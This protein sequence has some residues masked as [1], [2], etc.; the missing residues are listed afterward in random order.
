MKTH[1]HTHDQGR[2][3]K[4]AVHWHV[5]LHG[6]AASGDDWMAFTRWLETD[7]TYN[8]AYDAVARIWDTAGVLAEL[9]SIKDEESELNENVIAFPF[10]RL[11]AA[12]RAR[13]VVFGGSFGAAI[14]AT[15]L[16]LISPVFLS[17]QSTSYSTGIGEQR[18]ITLADG[19]TVM[20]NT[21]TDITIRYGKKVRQVDMKKGEAFFSVHHDNARPFMV[22]VNNLKVTDVGTRFDIRND[23][24][25]TRVSVTE[26]IV[27]IGLVIANGDISKTAPKPLRLKAGEQAEYRTGHGML[28]HSFNA[29][30]L[31]A[32]KQG[33]LVFE[34]DD[35]DMVTTELNR[36]FE[37]PIVLA[38]ADL[39][40]L[41]FSGVLQ[42]H[43]QKRALRDL[44]AFFSLKAEETNSNILLHHELNRNDQ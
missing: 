38:E 33:Q 10:H 31:T 36:Y 19:T 26:G 24:D 18:T 23:S 43:D 41:R 7:P 11:R 21:N 25:H 5:R 35:L 4:E 9:T 13:P 29:E 20:L 30:Q 32:W 34:N 44:T 15:L 39:G 1:A 27:D 3:E 22:A 37:R 6:G 42:I 28:T 8:A 14:A 17:S 16:V 12:A 2:L 40:G